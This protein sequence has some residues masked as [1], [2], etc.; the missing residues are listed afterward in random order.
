[1]FIK[2]IPFAQIRDAA[3]HCIALLR[4]ASE[5]VDA[6]QWSAVALQA[7]KIRDRLAEAGSVALVVRIDSLVAYLESSADKSSAQEAVAAILEELDHLGSGRLLATI[8]TSD[9][10]NRL[11]TL[12]GT[13]LDDI[14]SFFLPALPIIAISPPPSG[15]FGSPVQASKDFSEMFEQAFIGLDDDPSD[16]AS[17]VAAK[18]VVKALDNRSISGPLGLAFLFARAWLDSDSKV[19]TSGIK[20][21]GRLSEWLK[22]CLNDADF[23]DQRALSQCAYLVAK[24]TG[25]RADSIRKKFFFDELL[26]PRGKDVSSP[27]SSKFE[28]LWQECV[29][30]WEVY[31]GSPGRDTA[32]AFLNSLKSLIVSL[33]PRPSL[34]NMARDAG[35]IVVKIAKNGFD[36]VQGAR[37]CVA[38]VLAAI[39]TANDS[40]DEVVIESTSIAVCAVTSEM[41]ASGVVGRIVSTT[42]LPSDDFYKEVGK[43]LE[44][45][46]SLVADSLLV[47][48]ELS[49]IKAYLEVVKSQPSGAQLYLTFD[50]I[51]DAI[52]SFPHENYLPI[53][54]LLKQSVSIFSQNE[55]AALALLKDIGALVGRLEMQVLMDVDVPSDEEIFDIF[56]EEAREIAEQIRTVCMRSVESGLVSMQDATDVRRYWHT[57]KGSARIAGLLHLGDAAYDYETQFN[58]HLGGDSFPLG[59][60]ESSIRAIDL[61]LG[62][63]EHIV[64]SG[65]TPVSRSAFIRLMPDADKKDVVQ[66]L[67]PVLSAD[68][69][70]EILGGQG[71]KAKDFVD[72]SDSD[73][74]HS[75]EALDPDEIQI[76]ESPEVE[77]DDSLI[78][79]GETEFFE[80][81]VVLADDEYAAGELQL[82]ADEDAP[83]VDGSDPIV[84][85]TELTPAES[86]HSELPVDLSAD[87]SETISPGQVEPELEVQVLGIEA[88]ESQVV[89]SHITEVVPDDMTDWLEPPQFFERD[90]PPVGLDKDVLSSFFVESI[91]VAK[92]LRAQSDLVSADGVSFELMRAA[93]SLAGMARIVECQDL[94]ILSVA[95]EKWSSFHLSSNV[96]VGNESALA[97]G[98]IADEIVRSVEAM[99]GG[100]SV[101]I[102]I[103]LA[104]N[105]I[106]FGSDEY[107][108]ESPDL[109]NPLDMPIQEVLA[110]V[111]VEVPVVG[112]PNVEVL[113]AG[114]VL[115]DLDFDDALM[116]HA[117]AE[118]A[119]I[120]HPLVIENAMVEAVPAILSHG[121]EIDYS[122]SDDVD[123]DL[124]PTLF[125]E[126]QEILSEMDSNIADFD[127]GVSTFTELNRSL[128]TLKGSARLCGMLRL[129]SMLHKMEDATMAS[130]TLSSVNAAALVRQVQS[131]LDSVRSMFAEAMSSVSRIDA[132]V[133]NIEEKKVREDQTFLRV[134]SSKV[135]SISNLMGRIRITQ[136]RVSRRSADGFELVE[137]MKSPLARLSDLAQ[138][139]A[140]EAE[141]RMDDGSQRLSAAGE[142][143]ALEMDRFTTLHEHTRRLLEA[144]NDVDNI[145]QNTENVYHDISEAIRRQV[146]LSNA[147]QSGVDGITRSSLNSVESRLRAAVRQACEDCD[148]SCQLEITG[149]IGIEREVVDKLVPAIEHMLR[150]SIAHG[151]ESK[152][153]RKALGKPSHGTISISAKRDGSLV[154]VIVSDDGMG[155]DYGKVKAKAAHIGLLRNDEPSESELTEILFS[156][157]FS[158]AESVSD[159]AGRGVGLDHVRDTVVKLGGRLTLKSDSGKGVSFSIVVPLS[160]G[161]VSGLLVSCADAPYIIP[162]ALIKGVET[163]GEDKIEN[164]VG[165]PGALVKTQDGQEKKLFS[166]AGLFGI[167]SRLLRNPFHQVIVTHGHPDCVLLADRM[168]YIN[169]L[170]MRQVQSDMAFGVGALGQV[171]LSDGRV[172]VVINPDELLQTHSSTENEF[173]STVE[174]S[175]HRE[176][177]LVLVVDDSITVRKVTT[178]LLTK[179]GMRV[180]TAENG[181]I[182]LEK[183]S[184]LRPD[185]IL[186]DIEMPVMDGFDATRAIRAMPEFSKIPIAIISSRNAEKHREFAQSI[187]ATKFFGK[188]YNE[189]DLIEWINLEFEKSKSSDLK[190]DI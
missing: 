107:G 58:Q 166:L 32:Q 14:G 78:A 84:T 9:A 62:H 186:M 52:H 92:S 51:I 75:P 61:F 44:R 190:M 42:S 80:A 158:T 1:M 175:L 16:D 189:S 55:L 130:N 4:V 168:E 172:A 85:L 118:K 156:A 96:P 120:A 101:K 5:K 31:N 123:M 112:M 43:E 60:M 6:A 81:P 18:Q 132:P 21:L 182:A 164:A 185:V 131:A 136:D 104:K 143:D 147:V 169:N 142:F 170:P 66:R 40:K 48:D 98:E 161:Y 25:A 94:E 176:F 179:I 180:E 49:G 13:G 70:S 149:D 93:H 63:C 8:E 27:S 171:L 139:I 24:V 41:L 22:K 117:V 184:N 50:R 74:P 121:F 46:V 102:N 88:I 187:G 10:A 129:G 91:E 79:S 148:K 26:L 165:H 127:P 97:L 33:T 38:N 113:N 83:E 30:K 68:K 128:H 73:V 137:S 77:S 19:D 20:T 59:L 110:E 99:S 138:M 39:K 36:D 188:P 3:I 144:V 89:E 135:L 108:A 65:E 116:E 87:F 7:K 174:P 100:S 155:I 133:E 82:F 146:E 134:P 56:H 126:A 124:L 106:S 37:D 152:D 162:S 154:S 86:L 163:L 69:K 15:E 90:W 122:I 157:G 54:T 35:L 2:H 64:Q 150:N 29:A 140:L 173:V 181:A 159:V 34:Y 111:N 95:V 167:Q 45:V 72:F 125:D 114:D 57:L 151:M 23:I 105:L 109:V 67:T 153:V 12:S 103:E 53:L 115:V 119:Q 47:A 160:S 183:I 11:R 145:F 76:F 141:A 177:P 71:E 17:L 28:P 178:R